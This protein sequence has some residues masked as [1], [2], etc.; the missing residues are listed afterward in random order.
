MGLVVKFDSG[1]NA[2]RPLTACLILTLAA[3]LTPSVAKYLKE[4]RWYNH[5]AA[6]FKLDSG[7]EILVSTIW[8]G[9]NSRMLVFE[10]YLNGKLI[11]EKTQL[12]GGFEEPTDKLA[13]AFGKASHYVAVYTRHTGRILM[14]SNLETNQFE[15]VFYLQFRDKLDRYIDASTAT[16]DLEWNEIAMAII[17]EN[18]GLY[19]SWVDEK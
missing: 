7:H 12:E 5:H 14:L 19:I 3:I 1:Q 17:K 11:Q 8:P 15:S 4:Y 10:I 9:H 18:P 2:M 16:K 6:T 13:I